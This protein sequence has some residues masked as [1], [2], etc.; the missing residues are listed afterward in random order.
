LQLYG[1]DL[2]TY[3]YATLTKLLIELQHVKYLVMGYRRSM[4][5]V[6]HTIAFGCFENTS[7]LHCVRSRICW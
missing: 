5:L 4:A 6:V 7:L 2:R 1:K 3:W